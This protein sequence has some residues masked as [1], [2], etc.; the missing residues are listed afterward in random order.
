MARYTGDSHIIDL[1]EMH[2][3]LVGG[4]IKFGALIT[5]KAR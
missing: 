1:F 5:Q 4:Y 2:R 3:I